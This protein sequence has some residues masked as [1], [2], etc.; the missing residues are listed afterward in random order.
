MTLPRNTT[1]LIVGAGPTG[2]ASAL[3]LIHYGFKD[4]VIVDAVVEGD[5]SSRAIVVHAATLEALDMIGCGNELV[6]KGTKMTSVNFDTRTGALA[7]LPF[8]SLEPYTRHPYALVIPQTFTEYVLGQK[9]A[10]LGVTVHRPHKVVDMKVNT[11]DTDLA[12]ITFEDGQVVTTRYIIAADGARSTIRTIA[13]IG[14]VDPK[15]GL[16]HDSTTLVQ[17][18]PADVTFDN[19]KLNISNL[20]GVM[21]ANTYFFSVPLPS[22]FN[23]YLSRK[24]GKFI[25][26]RIVRIACGVP[27]GEGPVPQAPSKAYVQNLID[28][29]GP[30]YLSSDPSAN[31]SGKGVC[32]KEV[33]WSSRVR[34]HSAIADTFFTRLP[35]GDSLKPA[36]A[37]IL[38]VGD[39]A[40]I[41]SPVG[42][43]G[44]NLGLRDA[45]FLGEVLAKHVKV[46][47]SKPLSEADQI[48]TDFAAERR[49]RALE[50]IGFT[51]SLLSVGGTKDAV[52]AWWLPIS[53]VTLRDW[54][55]WMVGKVYYLRRRVMWNFSGLGRR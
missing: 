28:K 16:E 55:L 42:G 12:D 41:H 36:G 34:T 38:L 15:D 37:A 27:V 48:L 19:P 44:M 33:I 39:A 49:T 51:K 52:V 8:D 14:F 20:S 2:L 43:Q 45:V 10:N 18:V 5:N 40:H 24:T 9:V 54:V 29:F 6:S 7:R 1:V 35:S 13:G 25:E 11:V 21:S 53:K 32:I 46:T 23:E 26:D 47:E 4:F 50:V 30:L 31:P 3:S 22:T 17:L